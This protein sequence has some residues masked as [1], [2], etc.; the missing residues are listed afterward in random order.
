MCAPVYVYG[1]S[2]RCW[3]TIVIDFNAHWAAL[4]TG[5]CHRLLA[6]RNSK[7][8]DA[9]NV[10]QCKAQSHDEGIYMYI[11]R[12]RRGYVYRGGRNVTRVQESVMG[13]QNK[14]VTVR[15]W[16]NEWVQKCNGGTASLFTTMFGVFLCIRM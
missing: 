11:Y 16:K 8:P 4:P 5:G 7:V 9:C 15:A 1:Q 13:I 6:G 2:H 10:L 12:G 14:S 3:A